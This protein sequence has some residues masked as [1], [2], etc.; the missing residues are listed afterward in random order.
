MSSSICWVS[1]VHPTFEL[2]FYTVQKCTLKPFFHFTMIIFRILLQQWW[3]RDGSVMMTNVAFQRLT[4]RRPFYAAIHNNQAIIPVFFIAFTFRI[5]LSRNVNLTLVYCAQSHVNCEN[6]CSGRTGTVLIGKRMSKLYKK[7]EML[8][9]MRMVVLTEGANWIH[10]W[11]ALFIRAGS[12]ICRLLHPVHACEPVFQSPP[13]PQLKILRQGVA[14]SS[15]FDKISVRQFF[16]DQ[17]QHVFSPNHRSSIWR[18]AK[19]QIQLF[20]P[21]YRLL[22]IVPT[23]D[24]ISKLYYHPKQLWLGD[25]QVLTHPVSLGLQHFQ[26]LFLISFPSLQG[27]LP[28][29]LVFL[30]LPP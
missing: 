21:Q 7:E 10:T 25:R 23:I 30:V 2:T 8:L 5:I 12:Y 28:H 24:S 15:F 18:F 26:P 6:L 29:V 17:P 9:Q 22:Q 14:L 20:F 4:V 16:G 3:R 13:P 19:F 27:L 1:W 11:V